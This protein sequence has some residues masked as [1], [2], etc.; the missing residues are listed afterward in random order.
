[1]F[2]ILNSRMEKLTIRKARASELPRLADLVARSFRGLGAG[3]YTSAEIEGALQHRLIRVDPQLVDAGT[4]FVAE[5]N[6]EPVGC[7]G[8]SDVLPTLPQLPLPW[9]RAE[10][11]AMFVLPEHSGRGV[12]RA[13]LTAAERAIAESGRDRAWLVATESGLGFYRAAGYTPLSSHAVPIPGGGQLKVTAM[14]RALG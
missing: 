11:R 4:Y 3:H 2:V 12:G 6:G 10:V 7:G 13:L 14:A 9:P 8:W 5:L 1:M